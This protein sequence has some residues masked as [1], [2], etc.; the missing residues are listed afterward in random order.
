MLIFKKNV[1]MSNY[2]HNNIRNTSIY[3]FPLYISHVKIEGKCY[4][5]QIKLDHIAGGLLARTELILVL[6]KYLIRFVQA[7]IY[8]IGGFRTESC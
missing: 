5:K 3:L 1:C 7:L 8:L 4:H 2:A 6:E